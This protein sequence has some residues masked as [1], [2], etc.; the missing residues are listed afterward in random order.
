MTIRRNNSGHLTAAEVLAHY[1]EE[2]FPDFCDPLTD[3]NQIGTFGNRPLHMASYH[4][5][6]EEIEALVEGGALVNVTGEKGKTPL[7]EAASQG[8]MEA[9]KFLLQHGALADVKDEFGHT[10]LDLAQRS[11]YSE[12]VKLLSGEGAKT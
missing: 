9:V 12:I 7:H 11:G 10:P 5:N 1:N 6:I 4:G 8:H 2:L 3:V